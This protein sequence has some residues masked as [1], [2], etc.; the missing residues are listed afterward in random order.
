M[1]L[2][3]CVL[4]YIAPAAAAVVQRLLLLLLLHL[5]RGCDKNGADDPT[6]GG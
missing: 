3:S 4:L 6:L 1:A 2:G 5:L